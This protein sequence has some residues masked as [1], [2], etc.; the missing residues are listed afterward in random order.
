MSSVAHRSVEF[1]S[2]KLRPGSGASFH[3]LVAN[4]SVALM[5]DWGM[6]V[7]A[8]GPSAADPDAYLLIRAYDSVEHLH[9]SQEAFY[10]TE[11]W[12]EG[13][14]EAILALIEHSMSTVAWLSPETVEGLRA[15]KF[16]AAE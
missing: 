12:R 5:R 11:I 15:S 13:P 16:A 6:D 2:Y 14:R 10:A 9:Q 8:F 4:R 7:V 3:D 1:R